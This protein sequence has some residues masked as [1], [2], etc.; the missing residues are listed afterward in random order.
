M[1]TATD[2]GD[3]GLEPYDSMEEKFLEEQYG[4]ENRKKNEH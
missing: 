3:N 1:V 4:R 2:K